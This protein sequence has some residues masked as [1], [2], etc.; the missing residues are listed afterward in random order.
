LRV[1]NVVTCLEY[2]F[3]SVYQLAAFYEK[4]FSGNLVNA[5]VL[6]KGTVS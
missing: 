2:V 1:K 3:L 6:D 5:N 4:L